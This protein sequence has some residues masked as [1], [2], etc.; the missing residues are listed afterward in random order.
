MQ[1]ARMFEAKGWE[2]IWLKY[3]STRAFFDAAWSLA[4]AV[5]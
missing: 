5:D 2:V 3:G 1:I 4:A